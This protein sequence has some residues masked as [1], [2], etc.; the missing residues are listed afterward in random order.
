MN[1]IGITMGCPAGIGPEIILKFF[2]DPTLSASLQPVVLGDAAVLERCAAEL[3]IGCPPISDWQPGRPFTERTIPVLNLSQLPETE[4]SWGHPTMET[5]RAMAHYIETGVDLIQKNIID[6]IT[7]C[8]IAKTTLNSAGY[9]Y[10]GHTEMLAHLTGTRDVV[11]MMAGTRLKVTLVTIHCALKT[12]PAM[13]TSEA[14]NSLIDVTSNSLVRDFGIPAP[15]IA[16]AGLNPHAGEDAL[17]GREERDIIRPA[18]EAAKRRTIDVSGPFPPDT[19]FYSAASGNYDAVVC[20]YHDQGLIP[21]KLLHFD[22]GV[23]VTLGL[24]IVRTSVDHGTAY[25]IAGKGV[26]SHLSLAAAV[27]LADSICTNRKK[28]DSCPKQ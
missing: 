9:D 12:V 2:A 23:N 3:G 25:D 28:F 17:F 22:D 1:T 24:P 6:G 7:T 21:F 16:V 15:K 20:M 10:P 4:F 13:I 8:P 26:A 18:V 27:N 11:M 19:V 14:V 5:G